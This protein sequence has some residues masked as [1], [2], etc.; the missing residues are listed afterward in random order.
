M[1]YYFLVEGNNG[2]HL[3]LLLYGLVTDKVHWLWMLDHA[4]CRPV[5][6]EWFL[7][8]CLSNTAISV[9]L[10]VP[11]PNLGPTAMPP[12]P[13][14]VG[15]VPDPILPVYGPDILHDLL[16]AVAGAAGEE[17]HGILP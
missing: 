9:P 15:H 17:P 1:G 7:L 16:V 11:T 5:E 2:S 3:L 14:P 10:I 6:L 8:H 13:V 4:S 12:E